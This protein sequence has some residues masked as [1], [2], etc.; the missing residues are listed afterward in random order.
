MFD[1][2]VRSRIAEG[3]KAA[4]EEGRKEGLRQAAELA[5]NECDE[6]IGSGG[7]PDEILALPKPSR[8]S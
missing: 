7:F 8:P 4:R 3:L 6:K 1:A 5:E 2:L